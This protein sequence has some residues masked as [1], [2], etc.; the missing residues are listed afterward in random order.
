[1][2]RRAG[3]G[4]HRMPVLCLS[5]AI[6]LLDQLSKQLVLSHLDRARGITVI[7]GFFDIHFVQNTGAAWG[8]FRGFNGWLAVLSLVMLVVIVFFRRHVLGEGVVARLSAGM[9]IGGIVGN[10]LDRLRLSY[11]VDF[12]NFHAGTH[13]FPAFNVAD[14]AICIGVGLYVIAQWRGREGEAENQKQS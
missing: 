5:F 8:I 1:M 7:P 13:Y 6:V 2:G 12:L 3:A 11:V 14:S 10:L 4:K 9:I